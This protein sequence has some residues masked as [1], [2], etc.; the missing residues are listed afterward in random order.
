MD[1]ISC[2]GLTIIEMTIAVVI[3]SLLVAT[4]LNITT[5]VMAF[6]NYAETQFV[7]Q[8][9]ANRAFQRISEI[10]RKVGWSTVAAVNY[11]Q[12]S[13]DRS[14]LRFRLLSDLDGNGFPFDGTSGD[15][16]WS[17]QIL[18]IR[19]DAAA[20]ALYVYNG[21]IIRWTLGRHVE[22]VS[23]ETFREDPSLGLRELRVT[24]VARMETR[25]GNEMRHTATGSIYM[26]N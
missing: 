11:P 21:A 18:T 9:E 20:E 3:L 7:A 24:V 1:R 19:R 16:E 5:D 13:A 17:D 2:R 14:E 23:F 25:D 10:V 26:R 8:S 12:V 15:L 4:V 22:S 6:A